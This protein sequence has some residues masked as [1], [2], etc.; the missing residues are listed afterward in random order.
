MNRL[1]AWLEHLATGRRVLLLTALELALLGAVNALEFPLSVPFMRRVSGHPYLDLCA[2]CSGAEIQAQL[3]DFGEAGRSLQLALMPTID[4]AIPLLSFVFGSAA[5]AYLL[6]GRAGRWSRVL[7]GL[8]LV[9]LTLDFAENAAIIG[10]LGGYP[11]KLE[12]LATAVGMLSGLKF[13]AYLIMVGAIGTLSI[14]RLGRALSRSAGP[15]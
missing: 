2:F 10:L 1:F 12:L 3:D 7:R 11:R 5:L 14:V 6:R 15:H 8:P 4:L 13:L 9:A